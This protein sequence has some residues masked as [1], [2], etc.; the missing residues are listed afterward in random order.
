MPLEDVTRR[1]GTMASCEPCRKRKARCDHGQ[2]VCGDCARRG[3]HFRCVYHPAPMSKP[4]RVAKRR[5]ATTTSSSQTD[6]A[7]FP[8]PTQ[9]LPL[10]SSSTDDAAAATGQEVFLAD[11]NLVR[12]I[13]H[14]HDFSQRSF[15]A[16][17]EERAA[18]LRSVLEQLFDPERT[19]RLADLVAKYYGH[20]KS[21][22]TPGCLIAPPVLCCLEKAVGMF[23]SGTR[24]ERARCLGEMIL[25]ETAKP[26]V[27][28]AT[29]TPEKFM[30]IFKDYAIRLEYLG[31]IFAIAAWAGQIEPDNGERRKSFVSSMLYCSGTCLRITRE[32][33][34]VNDMS[35]WLGHHYYILVATDK[36]HSS[37][38]GALVYYEASSDESKGE[39]TWKCMGDLIS[40]AVAFG[41]FQDSFN[42]K[43]APFFLTQWRQ[44]FFYD[45]YSKDKFL[46]NLFA[47]PPRLL[48]I[49]SDVQKPWELP[50][51]FLLGATEADAAARLTPDGWDRHRVLSPAS[52]IRLRSITGEI[53]E[54]VLK[55]RFQSATEDTVTELKNT[56]RR[57]WMLWATIPQHLRYSPR[58]WSEYPDS[59]ACFMLTSVFLTFL[60]CDILA[61]IQELGS[62]RRR[63]AS[64]HIRFAYI[65][66]WDGLSPAIV[67]ARQLL[68]MARNGPDV[69]AA[70]LPPDMDRA[71]IV[72][73]LS[74][75]VSQLE[76][77]AAPGEPNYDLCKQAGMAISYAL[78]ESLRG[79]Q[80]QTTS[81]KASALVDVS[82]ADVLEE[83]DLSE[84]AGMI[85]WAGGHGQGDWP[86][87]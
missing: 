64:F 61:L 44:K 35:L 71:R 5:V 68:N 73:I 24:E 74:V 16:S 33:A 67:L 59:D 36:G 37:E 18:T 43:D 82:D 49:Y 57:N 1:N 83:F 66:L 42:K 8:T 7:P 32:I 26:V 40:D 27:I 45:L 10:P 11:A 79:P 15:E 21:S 55:F 12:S 46:A 22:L 77:V 60:H 23:K 17:H 75:F 85:D 13:A 38:S 70:S 30:G 58:S 62:F 39:Q 52:W 2:P 54:T 19:K 9:S 29:T 56:S 20:G 87:A 4:R 81:D 78:D 47:R 48:K 31:I 53:A 63:Q 14:T 6:E 76:S 65:M 80:A 28:D 72:R 86:I 50:D 34:T 41:I 51:E 25:S 3:F 69:A 84:W